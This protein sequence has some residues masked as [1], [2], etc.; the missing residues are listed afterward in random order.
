MNDKP[1][2]SVMMSV[3]NG[4]QYLAEATTSILGQ[5]CP[6][7]EFIIVDDGS[8][9]DTPDIL[10]SLAARDSRVR[11]IS[12]SHG[13]HGR[14]RNAG[15]AAA[16]GA[17][18]AHMDSDDIAMPGRLAAQLDFMRRTGTDICGSCVQKFGNRRGLLWFPEKHE[19]ILNEL[20]FRVGLLHPTVMI[21]AVIAKAH[22]Y[23]EHA[24][25]D[26]Y[27]MWT[28]LA[29]LYR[30]G[31]LPLVLL[32]ER[33]HPNQISQLRPKA[34]GEDRRKYRDR[35]LLVL[36]PQATAAERAILARLAENQAFARPT[37]LE[38]AGKWLVR[39]A[40]T[41]DNQ[42]LRKMAG[43]WLTACQRSAQLGLNVYRLYRRI[44]PEFGAGAVLKS[45]RLWLTCALRLGP[46]SRLRIKLLECRKRVKQL[47]GR[48]R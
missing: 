18:I 40:Q 22:P 20:I 41:P 11:L 38:V 32:K 48:G 7:F 37:D 8:T 46:D 3:Y 36:F 29:P 15:I 44:A 14:A 26:D 21:R 10:R 34:M 19:A 35:Y 4:Q 2:I 43:R 33:Y 28:R 5:T 1:L 9:D 30:M 23:D 16:R 25:H 6:N 47:C 39:L 12:L 31:N 42:L 27:E 24:T 17:Y 45:R 13:G